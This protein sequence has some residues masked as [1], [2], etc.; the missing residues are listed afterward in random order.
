MRRVKPKPTPMPKA[1][2]SAASSSAGR[3][4][5]RGVIV[6]ALVSTATVLVTA[7]VVGGERS[8]VDRATA[9][10]I[11][12]G[13]GAITRGV[14]SVYGELPQPSD[15]TI[16]YGL[17]LYDATNDDWRGVGSEQPSG[18]VLPH[19]LV[20]L[21]HGL[22]EPGGIWD[23]LAPALHEDGHTVLR[24]DYPNDQAILRSA[25]ELGAALDVLEGLGVEEIDLVCHSM[26]GLVAREVVTREEYTTR[27]LRVGTMITLGTPHGGSPWA[28]LRAVAEAREQVQ[29]WAESD[30][31]DPKRLSG[32]LHDGSGSAGD[33][34]LPGS[35]FL[36]ALDA[37]AMPD[38][39]RVI[40]VVARTD[41]A[42]TLAGTLGSQVARLTLRDLLG[43]EEAGVVLGEVDRLGRELGDGVV[44]VSSAAMAG[45]DEVIEV[46]ANHRSMIR[47]IELGQA[48]RRINGMPD[49]P[50]PPAI[51]IVLDR[52]RAE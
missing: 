15:S 31:L 30:D 47:S 20:L 42:S 2:G 26:G 33:D 9:R 38:D 27:G 1:K 11:S 17:R 16:A 24:F 45:A 43:E 21:I 13:V 48:I 19:G 29:R 37:K 28:R 8:R 23:Q 6:I 5:R 39:L 32:F 50:Q 10:V 46:R 25:D 41:Q 40:C 34:L 7:V 18:G 12:G 3:L 14:V 35:A 49:G 44:P 52:L 51:E 36:R 4:V 22:D